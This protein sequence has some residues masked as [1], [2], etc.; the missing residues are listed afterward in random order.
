MT[1]GTPAAGQVGPGRK[2]LILVG[3]TQTALGHSIGVCPHASARPRRSLPRPAKSPSCSTIPYGT[4]W[5]TAIREPP[6]TRRITVDASSPISSEEQSRSG[7]P[8][9]PRQHPA[10]CFLGMPRKAVSANLQ[11]SQNLKDA[12]HP[13]RLILLP[14][15]KPVFSQSHSGCVGTVECLD[16]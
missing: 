7:I 5:N 9:S 16:L 15:A 1:L 4:V 13:C 12:L 8:Y 11:L 10:E 6:T 3:R 2:G 14:H